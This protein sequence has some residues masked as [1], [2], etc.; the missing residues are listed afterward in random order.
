MS[1]IVC[2]GGVRGMREGGGRG[3]VNTNLFTLDCDKPR[4]VPPVRIG[5]WNSRLGAVTYYGAREKRT[6]ML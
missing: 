4:V 5:H 2:V 1:W 3:S 6:R